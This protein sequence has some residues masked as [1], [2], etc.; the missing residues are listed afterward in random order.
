MYDV[1][2]PDGKTRA[3]L[4]LSHMEAEKPQAEPMPVQPTASAESAAPM[5]KEPAAADEPVEQAADAGK[6]HSEK[7]E[8][9][10]EDSL[11]IGRETTYSGRKQ[12][13]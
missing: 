2:C 1:V 6:P 9:L 7:S 8:S 4:C 5:Q 12:G 13:L 11:A 10:E 3:I